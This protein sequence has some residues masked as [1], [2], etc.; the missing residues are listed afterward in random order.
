MRKNVLLLLGVFVLLS[1][2]SS[3]KLASVSPNV[4]SVTVT[5]TV[6][7]EISGDPL[8]QVDVSLVNGWGRT[9]TGKN[10]TYRI[11]G[12]PKG[13]YSFKFSKT[14]YRDTLLTVTITNT[15]TGRLDLPVDLYRSPGRVFRPYSSSDRI[16][17][18]VDSLILESRLMRQRLHGNYRRI[19]QL[20]QDQSSSSDRD[21]SRFK[22]FQNYFINSG[23]PG[24]CRLIAPDYLDFDD[25]TAHLL[26]L[27]TPAVLKVVNYRL[28]YLV[29]VNLQSFRLRQTNIGLVRDYEASFQFDPFLPQDPEKKIEIYK[30]RREAFKGTLQHFLMI[31]A[32]G[33]ASFKFGYE[34]FSGQS[35]RQATSLGSSFSKVDDIS[36]SNSSLLSESNGADGLPI[37]DFEGE[38]R[39]VYK[40]ERVSDSNEYAGVETGRFKTSWLSLIDRPVAVSKNGILENPQALQVK[41][42]WN[43]INVCQM[44]PVDYQSTH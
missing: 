33:L 38:V 26:E 4:S 31:T 19:N 12:V 11:E 36:L 35:Q 10:G 28:G 17:H 14:G 42:Y 24:E 27:E 6:T 22:L 23:D 39:V 29:T 13:F 30:I 5:G 9:R 15:D 21:N 43:T 8:E 20:I 37:L 7:S 44:L 25:T 41:G 2:S 16:Q 34:L 3:S 18:R 32:N 40:I 1:C